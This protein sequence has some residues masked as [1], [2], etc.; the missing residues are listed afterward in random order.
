M[1]VAPEAPAELAA[2]GSLE[3]PVK[4]EPTCTVLSL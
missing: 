4:A 1:Q 3:A 2:Q